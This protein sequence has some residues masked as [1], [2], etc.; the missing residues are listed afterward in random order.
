MKKIIFLIIG[1]LIII[2]CGNNSNS[3][4]KQEQARLDS[5]TPLK[6]ENLTKVKAI[7]DSMAQIEAI[8]GST[9]QIEELR[10]EKVKD[11]LLKYSIHD[12]KVYDAPIKTQ[13]SLGVIIEDKKIDEQKVRDLLN[14]LYDNT[15]QRSGFE[16][17]KNPTSIYIYSYTS[18]EKAESGMAQWIG[19][20]SKSHSELEPKVK[21]NET[22]FNALTETKENK[23]GL[24]HEQ[25][26]DIWNKIIR[27]EDRALKEAGKKH[28]LDKPGLTI[29]DMAKRGA[30]MGKLNKKYENDILTEYGLERVTLDS[31]S[32]EGLVNGWAFP[33][34]E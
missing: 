20:I 31:I 13:V 3:E 8:R 22:Q 11:E 23:W 14:H 4:K 17:H 19:M 5:I 24:T 32:I 25:R 34:E 7:R 30:L 18:S 2:S 12:E 16:Y 27:A 26:K 10:L 28:P 1:A 21:I 9:E 15:K 33:K 6:N 29:E